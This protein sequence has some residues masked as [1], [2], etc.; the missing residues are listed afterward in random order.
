MAELLK[1]DG[2][3][4]PVEPKDP[5]KGFTLDELY[6]LLNVEMIEVAYPEKDSGHILVVDEEGKLTDWKDRVNVEASR[7]YGWVGHDV[8]VGDA[9]WCQSEELK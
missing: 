2:T 8:I 7:R 5:E 1:V 3:I 6:A 4:T 9:L